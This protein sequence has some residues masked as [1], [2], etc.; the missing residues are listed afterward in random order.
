MWVAVTTPGTEID[1]ADRGMG[2]LGLSF[3]SFAEQE[4]K[5][6]VYREHI[7]SCEPAGLFVNEHVAAVNFL[8]CHAD[9]ETGVKTGTRLVRTFGYLAAQLVS[10]REGYPSRSY[11][12]F[13]LLPQ[14]RR[15]ATVPGQPGGMP[16]GMCIGDPERITKTLRG[17]E[18]AGVDSVNFLLNMHETVPHEEVLA[19]LR[20]FAKEVMP[21]FRGTPERSESKTAA[22]APVEAA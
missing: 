11:A 7:R 4:K 15:Q 20:L 14:L 8:Y 9:E 18:S 16:E 17:W 10:A 13:G 6:K 3:A 2:A 19:S 22:A 21:K 5:A 1:A 12:S